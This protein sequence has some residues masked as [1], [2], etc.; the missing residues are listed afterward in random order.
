MV[1]TQEDIMYPRALILPQVTTAVR[2]T[3]I[4]DVG[5]IIYNSTTN[6]LN[7]CK[8]KAAGAGNWE[9]ITSA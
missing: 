8:T 4:A 5:T 3:M 6:K 9:A 7:Y 1:E 2:D